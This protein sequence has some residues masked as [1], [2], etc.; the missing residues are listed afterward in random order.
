M[1]PQTEMKLAKSL[2][3]IEVALKDLNGVSTE[4]LK[5]LQDI[6]LSLRSIDNNIGRLRFQPAK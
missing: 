6:R 1:E 4:M 2:N 5:T 3:A